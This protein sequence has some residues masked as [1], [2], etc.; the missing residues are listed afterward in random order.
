MRPR[1]YLCHPDRSGLEGPSVIKGR[2]DGLASAVTNVITRLSR[3]R[4]TIPLMDLQRLVTHFAYKIELKPEGG[5]IAR[6]TDPTVPPLEAPT[7]EELQ[8]KIQQNILSALSAEFPGF[9][10][11][12]TGKHVEMSFHVERTPT[13]GFSIHSAD[14]KTGIIETSDHREFESH[15]LEK[16]L[17]LAG[18]HLAPE[19][20]QA[21][22]A[23]AGPATVKVVV[24]NKTMFATNTSAPKITFA[25]PETPPLATSGEESISFE[26]PKANPAN[27]YSTLD[28][29]PI[30][31]ETS[32]TG[33]VFGLFLL[34]L[35]LGALTY[36]FFRYR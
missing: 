10:L 8:Q 28:N 7:R 16:F 32:N 22:A 25:P 19:F 17:N 33:K 9:K 18:A 20:C 26:N 1:G 5:F 21:L 13:G 35:I 31:P 27:L 6:A 4:V 29:K 36:F 3:I 11:P 30:T 23:Q 34:V 2:S 12:P 15:F 14:P 24:N